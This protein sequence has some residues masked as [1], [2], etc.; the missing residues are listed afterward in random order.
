MGNKFNFNLELG[1]SLVINE[2]IGYGAW[3]NVGFSK[4]F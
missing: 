1:P 3:I 4:S 2:E